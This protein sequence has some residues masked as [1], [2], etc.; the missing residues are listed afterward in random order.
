MRVYGEML[1]ELDDDRPSSSAGRAATVSSVAFVLRGA[2]SSKSAFPLAAFF[3]RPS[4]TYTL[5]WAP[6]SV[7]TRWHQARAP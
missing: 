2:S 6:A 4:P 7:L 5:A 1:R 3:Y